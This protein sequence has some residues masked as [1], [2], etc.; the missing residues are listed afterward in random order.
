MNKNIQ[1]QDLEPKIT[2]KLGNIK[3]KLF[4]GIVDWKLEIAEKNSN[5]R[6]KL[7]SFVEHPH[8]Y[9]L[10]KSGDLSNLLLSENNQP[11]ELLSTKSIVEGDI[12]YQWPGQIVDIL[13]EIWKF[14]TDNS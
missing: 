14:F 9:T 11:K 10:G 13:L 2:K 12:T 1:L 7:F 4:K 3:K 5:W 8:V 6:P